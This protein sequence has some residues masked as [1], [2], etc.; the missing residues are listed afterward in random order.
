MK[1]FDATFFCSKYL[2]KTS[3]KY[4]KFGD[5][6][7]STKYKPKQILTKIYHTHLMDTF[8]IQKITIHVCILEKISICL[9]TFINLLPFKEQLTNILSYML[10]IN[11]FI[12][13]IFN[14]DDDNND[15][16]SDLLLLNNFH[17]LFKYTITNHTIII[18]PILL[19]NISQ[20][21]NNLVFNS[22]YNLIDSE[23]YITV[24]EKYKQQTFINQSFCNCKKPSAPVLQEISGIVRLQ[25]NKE[26]IISNIEENM[27]IITKN[28]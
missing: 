14:Y 4:L 1:H 21:N 15:V 25:S 12:L 5:Y 27:K 17:N 7:C 18:Y 22:N 24:K 20:K 19:K 8:E 11:V 26:L 2:L 28:I 9:Y 13:I 3:Y 16:A 6:K 23:W 10:E